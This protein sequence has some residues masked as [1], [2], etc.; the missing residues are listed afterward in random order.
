MLTYQQIDNGNIT[1]TRK[2]TGIVVAVLKQGDETITV[3][4]TLT[5][6]ESIAISDALFN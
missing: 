2:T 3:A 4:S 5:Y 1:V 6:E